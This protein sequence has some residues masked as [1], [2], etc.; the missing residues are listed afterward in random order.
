MTTLFPTH[1]ELMRAVYSGNTAL[2]E[3]IIRRACPFI[4]ETND[5][6]QTALMLAAIYGQEDICRLLLQSGA[7]IHIQDYQGNSAYKYA[8]LNM[9]YS[10]LRIF[11]KHLE[12]DLDTVL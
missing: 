3:R 11:D 4:D 7:S 8:R 5:K 6:G 1:T 10:I 12:F 2:V 9:R